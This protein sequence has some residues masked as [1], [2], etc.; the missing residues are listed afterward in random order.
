[1]TNKFDRFTKEARRVLSLANEEAT[2]L[3][4]S[5]IGSEHILL[6]LV[7]STGIAAHVL[8]D[9][10]LGLSKVRKAVENIVGRGT[11]PPLSR[12]G[13]TPRAKRVIELAV[14]EARRL[15]HYYIGTEHLLL[16]LTLEPNGLA[17][18]ALTSLDMTLKQVNHCTEQMIATKQEATDTDEASKASYSAPPW[19]GEEAIHTDEAPKVVGPYSQAVRVGDFVFTAGQIAIDPTINEFIGGEIAQQ[20]WQVLMNLSAVL[21]AAGSSLNQVVKTTVFLTNMD[22]YAAMNSVYSN[23][24]TQIKP[25]R[26]TVVV[27]QLPLDALVEIECVAVM[28]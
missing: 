8:S 14:D 9:F 6:G 10:G 7:R 20:T 11:A 2:V 22:N 28:R 19:R 13:L 18:E 17:A 27:A 15:N 5:Y 24:F 16:G 1:M 12:R 4:H 21:S 3:N 23:F 25:A 26:S